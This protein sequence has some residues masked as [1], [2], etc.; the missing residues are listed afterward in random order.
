MIVVSDT[1]PLSYLHQI[2]HYQL[3]RALYGRI[4]VP[5]SVEREIKAAPELHAAVDWSFVNEMG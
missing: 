2:G 3:L 5:R 1:S 4:I